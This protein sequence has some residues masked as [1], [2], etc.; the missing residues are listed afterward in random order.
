MLLVVLAVA[1]LCALLL[2]EPMRVSS[3]SM[4]PS[5]APGDEVLV[6]KIG[7]RAHAPRRGDVI[8]LRSPQTGELML[9][10]VAAL[11]GDQVGIAD[12]VLVVNERQIAEPYVDHVQVD[13]TYYGPVQ[14]PQRSVWVLGDARAGS[15]DSRTFGA[16]PLGAIVGRVVL[17]LW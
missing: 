5:Y 8:V 6:A 1:L 7:F 3:R 13:G 17:Q 11:G 14:V 12:G 16:V 9:K 4:S 15:V 2:A 10:R